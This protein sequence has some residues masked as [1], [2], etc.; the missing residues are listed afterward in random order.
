M[1]KGIDF[2]VVTLDEL[3]ENHL[4][5]AQ[6][7]NAKLK[8]VPLFQSYLKK[9]YYPYYKED[10]EFYSEKLLNT[11][12]VILETDLP[13][14]EKIESHSVRKIKQL[15]RIMAQRV[16]FTPNIRELAALIGV[17]RNSLLSYLVF[18]QKAHLIGLLKQDVS[19]LRTLA[20]PEK[21]YLDNTNVIYALENSKP[22]LGNIRETFFFNQLNAV[23]KVT[24]SARTDFTVNDVFQFEV[25]GKNKGR[26]QISGL[27]NVYS[28]I[29]NVEYGFANKIPLRMFGF[30]YQ[31]LSNQKKL[32]GLHVNGS[33][34]SRSIRRGYFLQK[35]C[36]CL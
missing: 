8:P 4:Y 3:L 7:V 13:A 11:V 23:S 22:D 26:E 27:D 21:I 31:D 19:G 28:A 32:T 18:L 15:L 36:F 33:G 12:N 10:E 1:E 2:P 24:S 34:F 30:L 29:D 17:S 5:L 6:Q 25:G 16:P 14:V 9:G 35:K 20:K